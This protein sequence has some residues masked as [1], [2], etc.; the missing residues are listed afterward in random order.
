MTDVSH[1]REHNNEPVLGLPETLPAGE[2]LLWQGSPDFLLL[3]R[4]VLHINK[5]IVWFV[6]IGVWRISAHW[7]ATGEWMFAL[8]WTPAL[9]LGLCLSLLFMMAWFYARTTVYS[10][11]SLRV[12]MRFGL[13]VP[14]TMNIPFT[15]IAS[16]STRSYSADRGNIALKTVKGA[17]VSHLV[18]WPN[19]RPWHW[20]A[21]QPMLCC[22]S[23][24]TRATEQLNHA[25]K[26]R[27]N[28]TAS[29]T[30][31]Q[32]VIMAGAPGT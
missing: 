32:E 9:A 28:F 23:D 26:S 4:R 22:I 17:R 27:A 20:L 2:K 24:F 1:V 10:I 13:A 14:I 5:I 11:T 7:Q 12:T 31:P 18:L 21:P 25:V 19:V 3:A 15:K 29:E 16:A 8:L 6:F 30:G